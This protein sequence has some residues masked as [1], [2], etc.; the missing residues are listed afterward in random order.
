MAILVVVTLAIIIAIYLIKQNIG[1]Q[2]EKMA[3]RLD[4]LPYNYKNKY[5]SFMMGCQ[6]ILKFPKNKYNKPH[7]INKSATFCICVRDCEKY[8]K[9]SLT[10][11]DNVCNLF[12]ESSVVF[13]ENASKDNSR[14]LLNDYCNGKPDKVLIYED[15]DINQYPRTVR[16]A[17]GRN[18]C[19][20]IAKQIGNE[21]YI[22][23]DFDNVI[24][25]L[26]HTKVES[27]L[28]NNLN[29]DAL[30]ANQSKNYYDFWALRTYDQWLQFD[31]MD[32]IDLP[33][34]IFLLNDKQR[35]IPNNQIIKVISAFGGL[36]IY[37]L[38][39]L[40]DCFYY[41][42]KNNEE[43]CEHVHLNKQLTNLGGQLFIDGNLIN[44]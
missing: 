18:I 38:S 40:R 31:W 28:M 3:I 11:L 15:Y 35:N 16:L 39:K 23:L 17:R 34:S 32:A 8:M 7:K 30:F 20:E 14:Q 33:L 25:D 9:N 13:Y 1:K 41:G 22:V 2:I 42:W 43:S 26:D 29:W 44:H 12:R 21:I 4:S 19:L 6:S 27:S 37:K 5:H 24:S 36:G 10:K